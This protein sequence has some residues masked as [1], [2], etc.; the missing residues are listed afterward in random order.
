MQDRDHALD[1]FRSQ[2]LKE[3]LALAGSMLSSRMEQVAQQTVAPGSVRA[4]ERFL[5][6]LLTHFLERP[7]VSKKFME[8]MNR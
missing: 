7:F 5:A 6:T 2:Q 8:E 3:A 1:S 4:L